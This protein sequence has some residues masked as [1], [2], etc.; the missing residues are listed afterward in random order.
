MSPSFPMLYE[1][2]MPWP[3]IPQRMTSGGNLLIDSMGPFV[4]S[5][6]GKR[7][8]WASLQPGR[9]MCSPGYHPTYDACDWRKAAPTSNLTKP[10]PH[11]DL[12][13]LKF[14]ILQVSSILTCFSWK[15][16]ATKLSPLE[17]R[18]LGQLERLHIFTS[19]RLSTAWRQTDLTKFKQHFYYN[20]HRS[21]TRAM[22]QALTI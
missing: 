16:L 10:K 3:R 4:F 19:N 1:R 17:S 18:K 2:R 5:A 12:I 15:Y 20:Q 22:R 6:R 11:E 9:R 7:G 14:R 8:S 13:A 21:P